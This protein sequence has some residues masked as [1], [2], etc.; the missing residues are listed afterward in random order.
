MPVWARDYSG[1][2]S[3]P[4]QT[5]RADPA[6]NPGS[7]RRAAQFIFRRPSVEIVIVVAA[8]VFLGVPV[9]HAVW[10]LHYARTRAAIDQRLKE[11]VDR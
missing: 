2:E 6:F 5:S 8:G 4:A 3:T 10:V 7:A 9:A 1:P 11:Y